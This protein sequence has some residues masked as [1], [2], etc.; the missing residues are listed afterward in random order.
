MTD[1][2]VDE[3]D[4]QYRRRIRVTVG[5]LKSLAARRSL[6]NPLK[7]NLYAIAL[8]SHKLIRRLAPLFYYPYLLVICLLSISMFSIKLF[9]T[10]SC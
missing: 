6:L 5:G 9:F 8:I 3:A 1:E 10:F 2:G 7:Y 4:K